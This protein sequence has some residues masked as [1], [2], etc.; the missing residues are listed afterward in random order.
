[1]KNST[2]REIYQRA[3]SLDALA[4]KEKSNKKLLDAIESY[5]QL[6]MSYGNHLND[7]IFIEIAKKCIERMRFIGKMKQAVDIHFEL[8]H[9]FREEPSYKNQLAVTYLL[10]NRL[11]AAKLVLHE[12][13]SRWRYNG[14]A[15]GNNFL[16]KVNC[17]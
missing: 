15:L 7:T 6:I 12:I 1:M 8:I 9:R 14:F 16:K 4:E 2:I 11:S 13:L 10:A 5:K 17:K 3:K